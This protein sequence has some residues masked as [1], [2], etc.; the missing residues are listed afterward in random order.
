MAAHGRVLDLFDEASFPRLRDVTG[1]IR[2]FPELVPYEEYRCPIRL[3]KMDSDHNH[4]QDHLQHRTDLYAHQLRQ[5][6]WTW[7]VQWKLDTDVDNVRLEPRLQSRNPTLWTQDDQN[8]LSKSLARDEDRLGRLPPKGLRNTYLDDDL[9]REEPVMRVMLQIVQTDAQLV[10][11]FIDLLYQVIDWLGGDGCAARCALNNEIP[12]LA[13]FEQRPDH[14]LN[15]SV[16]TTT[17]PSTKSSYHE[18]SFGLHPPASQHEARHGN[19]P[20]NLDKKKRY[21]AACFR[22]RHRAIEALQ[23]AGMTIEQ[24][25]NYTAFQTEHPLRTPKQGR[26]GRDGL[27]PF[28]RDMIMTEQGPFARSSAVR[29]AARPGVRF[30]AVQH[31]TDAP[32]H[33]SVCSTGRGQLR[34][35]MVPPH[36]YTRLR[37][38]LFRTEYGLGTF[39]QGITRIRGAASAAGYSAHT[40]AVREDTLR[41]D[42]SCEA[43]VPYSSSGEDSDGPPEVIGSI[44]PG[45]LQLPIS[46]RAHGPLRT[47]GQMWNSLSMAP[48]QGQAHFQPSVQGWLSNPPARVVPDRLQIHVPPP[49]STLAFP[50]TIP[51]VHP[52]AQGQFQP[53]NPSWGLP[54]G[55]NQSHV[56]APASAQGA[57]GNHQPMRHLGSGHHYGPAQGGGSSLPFS[58]FPSSSSIHTQARAAPLGGSTDRPPGGILSQF[59]ALLQKASGGTLAAQSQNGLPPLASPTQLTPGLESLHFATSP[60]TPTAPTPS[61]PVLNP[62]LIPV[63][64]QEAIDRLTS[65][66]GPLPRTANNAIPVLLYFPAIVKPQISSQF[67]ECTDAVM[68]GYLQPGATGIEFTRAV[69]FPISI[70]GEIRSCMRAGFVTLEYYL[71]GRATQGNW[72]GKMKMKADISGHGKVYEKLAMAHGLM[73]ACEDREE[74]VTKRWRVTSGRVVNG[75][76]GAVWEGWGLRVDRMLTLSAEERE[77]ACVKVRVGGME[78]RRER[79]LREEQKR[80]EKELLEEEDDEDEEDDEEGQEFGG[81]NVL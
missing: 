15:H 70:D 39:G 36:L 17:T 42:T 9:K 4:F 65:L 2:D 34:L 56:H 40:V 59:H 26:D 45:P 24:I 77:G 73:T 31:E 29:S 74:D 79:E 76:R 55:G 67:D 41:K 5:E 75:C 11:N 54:H 32:C 47:V 72:K 66:G 51:S 19:I 57:P 68:L 71:P 46:T 1:N 60:V 43:D 58:M 62:N 78:D 63:T 20:A 21:L 22:A 6:L 35:N 49:A 38:T 25:R 33:P 23:G 81:V 13:E 37:S 27:G 53:A 7:L 50:Q 14:L 3:Y 16:F 18:T 48:Q 64:P 52:T 28:L 61:L 10:P 44:P 69:F 80:R 8:A 12:T 30:A